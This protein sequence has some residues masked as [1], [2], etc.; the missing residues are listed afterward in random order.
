MAFGPGSGLIDEA[1][2]FQI[3]GAGGRLLFRAGAL[4]NN[5]VLKSVIHNGADITDRPY[6]ATNGDL[7][8]LEIVIAEPAQVNGTAKN[9]RGE[10]VRDFRVALF[11]AAAR[12]SLLTTRFVH[13][14]SADPSGRFQVLRLPAGEYLGVAVESFEQGQEWDPAF[15]QRVLPAARRFALKEGQALTIE[16]PYVE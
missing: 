16:L 2:R 13:T 5:L 6:D 10:P 15:Q 3:R 4:P 9:A 14:G 1:G 7:A 11:P 8:G 12:P